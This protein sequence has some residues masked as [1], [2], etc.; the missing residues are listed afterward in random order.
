MRKK[1]AILGSTGSIGVETLKLIKK[2]K[3]EFDI[4]L[5]STNTNVK[6]VYNQAKDF[7]VKDVIVTDLNSF[8]KAKYIYRDSNIKF[9]NSFSSIEKLFK[10]KELFYTM[11]SI[12]GLDGLEPSLRLIKYS[13][14]IAIIN[15][16]SLI[17][18]WNLIYKNL[19][20]H[21]T[22]FFPLDS[23][24]FSIFSLMKNSSYRNLEKVI[25]TAS[26]GPFLDYNKIK[27]SKIKLSDALKHPNWHMGKKISIDSAT[28]M[29]KLFEVIEAKKIFKLSYDIIDILIHPKSYVHSIL[30]FN[31]GLTKILIHEPKMKI[32]IHNSLYYNE[33]K[34]IKSKK[35]DLKILNNLNFQSIDYKKFPLLKL[36][37]KI[38]IKDS[39]FET[40]LVCV[41]DF[42]V[43][44]FLQEKI[45]YKELI[46][47]IYYFCNHKTFLKFKRISPTNIKDIYKTRNFVYEMLNNYSIN[48]TNVKNCF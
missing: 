9:Y 29:N 23:E 35:L 36:I 19:K 10:K 28:M 46:N 44:K 8:K 45:T 21:K 40:V 27:F 47:N 11:I 16:E 17:C 7:N 12:V 48:F 39:L 33:Y 43:E 26:G 24:H 6:K 22:F 37:K 32:P 25:I 13:K 20:K 5:L 41:N 1:I 15:K 4:R 30:K 18:G 38:P 3:I 34:T 31:N 42:F 2:N 14:N